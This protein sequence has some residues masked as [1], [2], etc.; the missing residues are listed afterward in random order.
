M[1][2]DVKTGETTPIPDI[3][4]AISKIMEHP[5]L[6]SMVA[7]ALGT[8]VPKTQEDRYEVGTPDNGDTPTTGEIVQPSPSVSADAIS[9]MLPMLSKLSALGT[10]T[11]K[12]GNIKHEQLLC[13]LKPYL[14]QSRCEAIDYILKISRMSVLL[15]GFKA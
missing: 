6:I 3:S 11:E 10:G 14:S 1:N 2:E 15:K 9:N 4:S 12:V 5:E 7:S 8:S 13:A